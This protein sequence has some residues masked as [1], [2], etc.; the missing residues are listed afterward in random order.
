[1]QLLLPLPG[2]GHGNVM[3]RLSACMA[4]CVLGCGLI[5][6]AHIHNSS[7][8]LPLTLSPLP[9]RADAAGSARNEPTLPPFC[10]VICART[11]S[12]L[13]T[14]GF[15]KVVCARCSW[16]VP[17]SVPLPVPLSACA[18]LVLPRNLYLLLESISTHSGNCN[19][20]DSISPSCFSWVWGNYCWPVEPALIEVWSEPEMIRPNEN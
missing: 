14:V 5:A 10:V 19:S 12:T 4:D 11:H 8:S 2:H 9:S 7:P 6:T 16:F 1:M 3:L 17:L 18:Y 13:R 15:Q 20:F